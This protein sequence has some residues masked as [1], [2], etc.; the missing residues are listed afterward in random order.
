MQ[1]VMWWGVLL[2]WVRGQPRGRGGLEGV[3]AAAAMF[4]GG[5]EA[6]LGPCL[7]RMQRV[8]R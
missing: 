4:Q 2:V 1:A 5:G 3:G 7:P 8:L 6:G